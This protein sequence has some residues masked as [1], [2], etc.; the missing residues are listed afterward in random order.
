MEVKSGRRAVYIPN[1][2][3]SGLYRLLAIR[4]EDRNFSQVIDNAVDRYLTTIAHSLPG[5]TDAEWC[6][7]FDALKSTFLSDESMVLAIGEE[8]IEVIE[9][10]ELDAKWGVV[11]DQLKARLS[12]LTYAESQAIAEMVETFKR[13]QRRGG[14]YTYSGVISEIKT[15]FRLETSGESR[16]ERRSM[17]M[18][19]D[20]L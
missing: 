6:T 12:A 17:R 14:H 1:D 13:F 5:F 19:P 15:Y 18:S 9:E 8:V 16:P 20:A 7:I 11:G 10:E 4:G 3:E 2:G